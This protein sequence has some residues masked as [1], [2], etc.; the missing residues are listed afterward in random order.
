MDMSTNGTPVHVTI[1][2][3]IKLVEEK[4]PARIS[5]RTFLGMMGTV[6]VSDLIINADVTSEGYDR[7]VVVRAFKHDYLV[8]HIDPVK[9]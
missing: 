5:V 3:L 6:D 7:K 2:Q 9:S 1:Q 8:F 4:Q